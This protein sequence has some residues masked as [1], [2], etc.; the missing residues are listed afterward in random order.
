MAASVSAC[1]AGSSPICSAMRASRR[2]ARA[3]LPGRADL[4]EESRSA[5]AE[6]A[7][8]KV[9][10]FVEEKEA[11]I[12]VEEPGPD[13]IF[14]SGEHGAS[15]CEAFECVD[16]FSLLA[17]GDGFVSECFRGFV[18]HAE[19]FETKETLVGHFA[20]FFAEIQLE[21]NFR[22]IEMAEGKM[23]GVAGYFAG[24]ACGEEHFDRA[25]V[26]AT[27]IVEIGDVVIGLIAKERH[28]V[29]DAEFAGSAD[30]NRETWENHSG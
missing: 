24:A 11:L 18:A 19:F 26:F 4:I 9:A 16:G 3:A 1:A 21:I 29:A 8:F 30:S 28:V 6:A 23:I 2:C 10:A 20:G 13:E 5:G 17:I 7:G 12:K 25:A 14:F 15:F 27:E 22:K